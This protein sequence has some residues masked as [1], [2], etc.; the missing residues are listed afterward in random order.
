MTRQK[1]KLSLDGKLT[2]TQCGGGGPIWDRE[3]HDREQA[4]VQGTPAADYDNV[5]CPTCAGAGVTRLG[6]DQ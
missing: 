6:A 1:L 5:V 2:C 3:L 4:K